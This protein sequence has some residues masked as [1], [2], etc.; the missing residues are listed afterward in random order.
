MGCVASRLGEEEEVVSICRE[1]KRLMKLV[2]ERRYALAEAHCRYCQALFAISA[3][4]N[5][6]VARHSTPSSPFLINFPPP[7]CPPS[8]PPENV[9]TNPLFLQQRPSVS[10]QETIVCESSDS[11][12]SSEYDDDVEELETV[13]KNE[14]PCGYFYVGMPP[15]M[16]S[17]H[18][19]FGWDFFN[20]FSSVRP[21]IVGE[22]RRNSDDDF[23]V[24]REEEGIPDLEE[25][26]GGE[27]EKK[28]VVD[29]VEGNENEEHLGSGV[30]VDR[31]IDGAD[32]GQAEK[33]L[34]VIDTPVRERELLDA[35]KDIEDHFIRVYDTG[36][37]VSRMLE[38]NKFHIQSGF[39][40]VKENSTKFMQAVTW[41]WPYTSRSPSCKSLVAS[42]S[43][44]SSTWSEYKNDLF[45][46]YGGMVSGSHSLTLGRL[47]A[48]E[49]KLYEE[50]KAGDSIRRL[51]ERKC[52]QLRNKD[53]RGDNML[54]VDK[55][56]ATVKDLYSRI[57]VA[58]R[59]AESIA[60][61]IQKLTVEELH[62]Q[63]IE[64]LQGLTQTWK[65]MLES[66][67]TQNQIMFEVKMYDRGTYGKFC[68]DSH[69]L[70]TLQLEAEIQNWR[71]RF[72][73]YIVAQKSYV[74][75]LHGWLSKFIVPEVEFC[76]RGRSLAPPCRSHGPPLYAI[77]HDWLIYMDN[78]PDKA[79][80]SA[81]KSFVK[82]VRALWIQQGD[83]QD[84][85]RKVDKL[86]KE[87][88]KKTLAYQK[89]ES[90][91]LDTK[92]LEYKP[93]LDAQHQ[94]DTQ[95]QVDSLAEKKYLLDNFRKKLEVEKEKHQNCMQETQG[96]TLNGFQT[97]FGLVFES[98][99]QFSK[100]SH[101]MYTDLVS[102][103]Q[104][105][106]KVGNSS[107]VEDSKVVEGGRIDQQQMAKGP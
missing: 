71:E 104:N 65:I 79:V 4:I 9:M 11:S 59:R 100:G 47:Y 56:R 25:E 85:K 34:T 28:A 66:H 62:P 49:K 107:C 70:A 32:V 68:S 23:R 43:K 1:R 77:C 6:F 93:E 19:D 51:Y 105:L 53:V 42:S 61:K 99:V 33:G 24:V 3:A 38:A 44:N 27:E 101:K 69:R 78:L 103:K 37:V 89:A 36:R 14:Q 22:F 45:D 82:D 87:L 17:P 5:L 2:V 90:R 86:A 64:L 46:D 13:E 41:N 102:S 95:H 18:R 98:L 63:I 8:P 73:D 35:L 80:A 72:V 76:S 52:S 50:V 94:D 16:P 81:M 57:L 21:E 39:E 26:G 54:S 84:Q 29:N 83:E 20:P 31:A 60:G 40:E 106:E 15:P 97:G 7:N 92:F 96:I 88:D 74:K 30:E 75:A 10:T 48:W 91:V 12:T 58:I 67:E 55:T